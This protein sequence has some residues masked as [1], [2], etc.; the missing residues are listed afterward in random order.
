[1]N[2]ALPLSDKPINLGTSFEVRVVG[3]DVF[4]KL[5]KQ[6]EGMK[7]TYQRAGFTPWGNWDAML[8]YLKTLPQVMTR[9]LSM[10]NRVVAAMHLEDIRA[11]WNAQAFA[12]NWQ[13]LSAPYLAQKIRDGLDRRTLVATERALNSMGA[14]IKSLMSLEVGITATED[15][16]PYMLFQEFGAPNNNL[17][18]R[19]L[20]GPT[21]EQ[22]L[23]RYAAV[24]K[25]FILAALNG[26]P[27]PAKVV[28]A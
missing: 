17:P 10:G 4:P 26:R 3:M 5:A 24:Y 9:Y 7:R 6:L 14:N 1:M 16:A 20:V 11:N 22:H 15:G 13:A 2:N 23:D 25:A 18:A 28:P 8:N 12:G 19:P 27:M 21:L